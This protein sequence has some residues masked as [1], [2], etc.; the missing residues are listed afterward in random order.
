MMISPG[1]PLLC[2]CSCLLWVRSRGELLL[3]SEQGCGH[4]PP[5]L[6]GPVES[7]PSFCAPAVLHQP[8]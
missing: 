2:L 1:T 8:A 7:S 5:L 3:G 4:P 6:V